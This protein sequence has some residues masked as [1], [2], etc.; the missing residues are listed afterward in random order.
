M[1]R[2]CIAVLGL[3]LS[4]AT[5]S[6]CAQAVPLQAPGL[7]ESQPLGISEPFFR[8]DPPVEPSKP[9]EGAGDREEVYIQKANMSPREV[10]AAYFEQQYRSYLGLTYIDISDL[11][12]MDL[13]IC[14]NIVTWSKALIQRRSLIRERG[15]CYVEDTA[16][17]YA[18]NY[19]GEEDLSDGR[20]EFWSRF[21]TL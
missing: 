13:Q 10:V 4:F 21:H 19:I 12:D 14:R 2:R 11:L 17:D 6:S 18:I 20:T 7:P 5:A 1:L 16:F 9:P 8:P 3:L 15:F